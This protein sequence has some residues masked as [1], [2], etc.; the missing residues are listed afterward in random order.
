MQ[1]CCMAS[2]NNRGGNKKKKSAPKKSAAKKNT[3]PKRSANTRKSGAMAN[4]QYMAKVLYTREQLSQ[5]I[6]AERVG[7]SANTM[8]K[9]VAEFNWDALRKRLLISKE[10]QLNNLYEQ[11]EVLNDEI[12]SSESKRP[13][14]K[15]ADVLVKLTTA[16]RTLET[17][18][19]IADLVEAGIR[20][21]KHL[22]GIVSHDELLNITENWNG[23]IQASIKK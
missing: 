2:S 22:Q 16:I 3:A 7:I 5:K 13:D 12:R 20:F 11:L 4:K 17:E 10:E 8:S 1:L 6:V 21:A 23:F 15:Q 9:W 14:T 18:L 19:A